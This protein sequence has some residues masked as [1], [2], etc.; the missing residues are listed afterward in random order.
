[1]SKPLLIKKLEA[2]L[3]ELGREYNFSELTNA[4]RYHVRHLGHKIRDG[5]NGAL[6]KKPTSG[7]YEPKQP[8]TEAQI[9]T[10]M[11]LAGQLGVPINNPYLWLEALTL[12]SYPKGHPGTR[13]NQR[14]EWLGDAVIELVV[15]KYLYENYP[16]PEGDLTNWRASLVNAS[17]LGELAKD[18]GFE[19]YLLLSRGESRDKHSKARHYIL[20]NAFEAVVGAIFVD[21]GMEEADRFLKRYLTSQLRGIIATKSYIDPKSRFQEIAQER[22]RITPTFKVLKETGP[23]HAKKFVIG[24]FLGDE[25]VAA[26]EGSSK[27]DA[28]VE[29][30]KNGLKAKGWQ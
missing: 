26:G 9:K 4:Q 20:A 2:A 21:R 11:D 8:Y 27:H 12:R 5:C 7:N 29:A 15:T 13:N 19:D 17:M 6:H 30:A 1:M 28:Q 16:N 24:I 10:V 23:D 3:R 14:L 18:L 22:Y 25:K